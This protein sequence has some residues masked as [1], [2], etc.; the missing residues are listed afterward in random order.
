MRSNS[1]VPNVKSGPA[2]AEQVWINR[3]APVMTEEYRRIWQEFYACQCGQAWW[4]WSSD[5][6]P[7]SATLIG[8][9]PPLIVASVNLWNLQNAVNWTYLYGNWILCPPHPMGLLHFLGGAFRRNGPPRSPIDAFS[10]ASSGRRLWHHCNTIWGSA[11]SSRRS[12]Q[13]LPSPSNAD[14][15]GSYAFDKQ[16]T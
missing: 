14:L 7:E 9:Y 2:E 15:S 10:E 3:R 1:V 6:P 16:P 8:F 13:K 12:R 11:Q 4:A 5:R